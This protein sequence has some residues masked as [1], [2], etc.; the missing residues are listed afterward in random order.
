MRKFIK[1]SAGWIHTTL[2]FAIITPVIYAFFIG[3]QAA[4]TPW[5]YLKCLIIFFPVVITDFAAD[6]CRHLMSYLTFSALTFTATGAAA[7]SLSASLHDGA[8]R[9]GYLLP[10]LGESA[11]I[12][13]NRLAAR[14]RKKTDREA[15]SIADPTF[16]PFYD[17]LKEPSFLSLLY[18]GAAYIF[19]ANF[20]SPSVCNIALFSSIVYVPVTFLYRYVEETEQYLSMNKR[21]CNLPSKRIYAIG[22][23]ILA[24]YLLILMI[25]TLPS[26]FTISHR[27]YR[28]LRELTVDLEIDYTEIM[29]EHNLEPAGE[30]FT[31]AMLAE[32]GEPTPPPWWVNFIFYSIAVLIFIVLAIALMRKIYAV[33]QDFLISIDEN[34]DI[35]EKLQDTAEDMQKIKIPTGRRRLS[36]K[37]Q[38][39]KKYR[40]MIRRHRKDR[41]AIYESPAEIEDKAGIA[42]TVETLAL[43]TQYEQARYGQPE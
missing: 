30:D 2:I 13:I 3:D 7:Y 11:F 4:V 29:Q 16:Y 24:L 34:G 28:D 9:L 10:V 23:G 42:K 40:K 41:P 38:I 18:F 8:L 43:H 26:L 21:T 37:E 20:N 1:I 19:A 33:F 35:V 27:Q 17:I 39:R 14:L 32:Y 36:E 5:L 25:L 31:A 6:R 12:I 15:A 22:G